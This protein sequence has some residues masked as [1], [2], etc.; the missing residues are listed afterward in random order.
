LAPRK[1]NLVRELA[2]EP[3]KSM[4][5]DH[6]DA[7]ATTIW[8]LGFYLGVEHGAEE[9]SMRLERC[10]ARVQTTTQGRSGA[11]GAVARPQPVAPTIDPS[12]FLQAGATV[13]RPQSIATPPAEIEGEDFDGEVPIP[14]QH[15]EKQVDSNGKLH[16][17]ANGPRGPSGLYEGKWEEKFTM[18]QL[19]ICSNEMK[20]R[21]II[22]SV[23]GNQCKPDY[24]GY[25]PSSTTV[26][27]A[28][29]F[30]NAGINKNADPD[31]GFI[32]T[33]AGRGDNISDAAADAAAEAMGI[34]ADRGAL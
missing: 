7:E 14:Q 34:S 6:L 30:I 28:E 33:N 4:I 18:D 3:V 15:K 11:N 20:G 13:E 5:P 22:A 2:R 31:D 19:R 24:N 26:V 9:T 1:K 23:L 12:A 25:P 17:T 10:L 29:K 8:L 32:T 27:I 16:P 21:A